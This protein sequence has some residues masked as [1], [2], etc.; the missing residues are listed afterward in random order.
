MEE[1]EYITTPWLLE[2]LTQC[3]KRA[4]AKVMDRLGQQIACHSMNIDI[5]KKVIEHS[6]S[7]LVRERC[8]RSIKNID[9]QITELKIEKKQA[10]IREMKKQ[11]TEKQ[12]LELANA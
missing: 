9:K 3:T 2:L 1:Q 7:M 5:L 11:E 4:G 6:D 10:E 12:Q 8:K